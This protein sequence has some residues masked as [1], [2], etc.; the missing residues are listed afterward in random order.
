MDAV[1][2][3]SKRSRIFTGMRFPAAC[4]VGPARTQAAGVLQRYEP[5]RTGSHRHARPLSGGRPL[6]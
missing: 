4:F 2:E 5:G 3:E 6:A 1:V